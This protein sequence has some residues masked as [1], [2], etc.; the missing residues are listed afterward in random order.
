MDYSDFF[1]KHPPRCLSGFTATPTRLPQ[2]KF[3]GHGSVAELKALG[4]NV[5][6]PE[7]CNPIF[8]VACKCAADTH[9][10]HAY[11][12]SNP[13]FNDKVVLLSPLDLE[14]SKCGRVTGLM[15][16]ARHGY[17]AELGHIVATASGRGDRVRYECPQ[18]GVQPVWAYTR[19]EYPD[20]LFDGDF[21]DF[22]GREQ[23]LF[24]WFSLVGKCTKCSSLF[25][26]AD[27]E[28]A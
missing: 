23:D 11:R 16:A 20:D 25:A 1:E 28:C 2:H 24:T 10:I 19:F 14:C 6:G 27:F 9:Y 4:Y 26:V 13:D 18:C 17:D 7:N 12:W 8:Q 3:D 5:S 21:A 22:A 15:D